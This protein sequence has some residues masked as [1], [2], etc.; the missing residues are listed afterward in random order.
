[1]YLLSCLSLNVFM[2]RCHVH[3]GV[4][5]HIY[6]G[7][8]CQHS[9]TFGYNQGVCL[10]SRR[11]IHI[12]D[13]KHKRSKVHGLEL[14]RSR[15]QQGLRSVLLLFPTIFVLPTTFM[16]GYD[17]TFQRYTE[18]INYLFIPYHPTLLVSQTY[19][20]PNPNPNPINSMLT[21]F[22]IP[23]QGTEYYDAPTKRYV[24]F[25][26]TDV[27]QMMGRA[28]RPQY[29]TKGVAVIMV[30]GSKRDPREGATRGEGLWPHF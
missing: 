17:G 5:G 26:I 9:S 24:D 21:L 12:S 1:M 23:M 28:G 22:L 16:H 13:V 7:M 15:N 8:G 4:G 27:L 2:F 19:P 10:R 20:N 14:K 29:D 3:A 11:H 30:R 18:T 25:P 6:S